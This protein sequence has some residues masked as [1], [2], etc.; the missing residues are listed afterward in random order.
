MEARVKI[1][2]SL[3]VTVGETLNVPL[4]R[5]ARRRLEKEGQE[6]LVAQLMAHGCGAAPGPHP[7]A[8]SGSFDAL[9]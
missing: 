3:E 7:A 4:S 6:R 2:R 8:A 9:A 1:Y 5:D